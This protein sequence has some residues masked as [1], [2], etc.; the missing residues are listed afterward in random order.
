[1]VKIL[2][3]GELWDGKMYVFDERIAVDIN[4]DPV[5]I[6]KDWF[7]GTNANAMLTV[8]PR[9]WLVVS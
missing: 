4:L 2:S 7:D 9:I 1:M 6:R 3:K 8:E 5:V